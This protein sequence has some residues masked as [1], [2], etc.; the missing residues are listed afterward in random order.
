[1][2]QRLPEWLSITFDYRCLSLACIGTRTSY[3]FVCVA[4]VSISTALSE[5]CMALWHQ[6]L[7]R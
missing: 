7:F 5:H 1:M 6:N 2:Q 4:F 3:S